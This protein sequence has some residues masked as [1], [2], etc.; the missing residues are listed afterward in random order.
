MDKTDA[1]GHINYGRPDGHDNISL[2]TI[3]D[4]I[5]NIDL[6]SGNIDGSSRM[7]TG[8]HIRRTTSVGTGMIKDFSKT[9]NKH[10]N[11]Y[12]SSNSNNHEESFDILLESETGNEG[13]KGKKRQFNRQKRTGGRKMK[14]QDGSVRVLHKGRG[15]LARC[16]ARYDSINHHLEPV[17][18]GGRGRLWTS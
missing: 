8:R 10:I 15:N 18:E 5:R 9:N 7:P 13:D 14:G 3:R 6:E 16:P 11:A 2:S 4:S 1:F 17:Y 12:F